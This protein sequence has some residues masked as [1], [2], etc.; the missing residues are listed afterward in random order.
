MAQRTD[1]G[2]WRKVWT[3]FVALLL[4]R[5]RW[6]ACGSSVH[7]PHSNA[8]Q[9]NRRCAHV[10]AAARGAI[11]CCVLQQDTDAGHFVPLFWLPPLQQVQLV[12]I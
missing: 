4:A 8:A 11:V 6:R 2:A 9:H 12:C 5:C 7:Q 1:D 10:H 3:G